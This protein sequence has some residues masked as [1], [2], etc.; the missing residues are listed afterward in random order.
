MISSA[1]RSRW[2]LGFKR[3]LSRPVLEAGLDPLGPIE[4]MKAATLGFS[5]MMAAISF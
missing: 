2:F 4:D 1:L 3:I 5:E